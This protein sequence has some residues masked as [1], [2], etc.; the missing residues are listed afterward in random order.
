M[1]NVVETW[2]IVL[3]FIN[4]VLF[5]I[6]LILFIP[7]KLYKTSIA[8]FYNIFKRHLPYI[9][10]IFGVVFFHLVEVNILDP[11]VTE[12]IGTDFAYDIQNIEGDTVLWF[13]QHWTPILVYFF[14]IMYIAVYPFTLW[15]SPVYLLVAD[16]KRSMKT[17][18]YGIL[19]IYAVALPFYLFMPITN[20]YKFYN[21][22]SALNTVIPTVES[23]FYATTTQNNCLPSLHV[24]TTILIAWSVH[25]TGNKK[26]SY[27]T[28]FCMISVILSVIYLAIHWITDVLC[29]ALLAIVVIFLLNR[30]I[31][32]K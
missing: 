19:L 31:K 29:G 6:G 11:P 10:L 20:V 25:L 23:F 14:V 7:R 2:L 5:V 17:L 3:G 28:Y 18:A 22:E 4:F 27:F 16:D 12:W 26:L 9:L 13:S 1:V 8:N 21:I 15:F 30:L 32:D 24:A